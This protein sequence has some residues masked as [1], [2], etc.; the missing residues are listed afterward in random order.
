MF[1]ESHGNLGLTA[2]H[3][4]SERVSQLDST[5]RT[6]QLLRHNQVFAT[7]QSLDLL[8][9]EVSRCEARSVTSRGFSSLL[10]SDTGALFS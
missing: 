3:T 6:Q 2:A 9:I 5:V 7:T 8:S 4:P 10:K 1:C